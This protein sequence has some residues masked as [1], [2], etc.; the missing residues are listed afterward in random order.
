M[1]VDR[2]RDRW[3]YGRTSGGYIGSILASNIRGAQEEKG[4]T[5]TFTELAESL[6][7]DNEY[8]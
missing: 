6:E 7:Q 2:V 8:V 1:H 4:P 5:F 3:V